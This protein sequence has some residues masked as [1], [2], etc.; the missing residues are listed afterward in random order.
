MAGTVQHAKLETRTAR[1]RLARGRQP[2]WQAVIPGRAHLGYQR[3]EEKAEGRWLLRRYVDGKY[4]TQALGRADDA[5][6]ADGQRIYSF[7]QALGTRDA[8]RESGRA[9]AHYSAERL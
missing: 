4:T 9:A 1:A 2:H 7:E 5:A 6:E 3:R 8:G